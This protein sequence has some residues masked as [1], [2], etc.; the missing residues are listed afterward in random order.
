M[1]EWKIGDRVLVKPRRFWPRA[2]RMLAKSKRAATIIGVIPPGGLEP[3]WF[4]VAFD[5]L[6][7]GAKT[8]RVVVTG[9]EISPLP[10]PPTGDE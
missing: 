8:H 4:R 3:A 1:S 5:A 9:S 10:S 6:R 7:H 2:E